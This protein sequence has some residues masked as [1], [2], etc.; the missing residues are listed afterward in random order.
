VLVLIFV[1][2]VPGKGGKQNPAPTET[3]SQI[4]TEVPT[5]SETPEETT[6]AETEAP[7]TYTTK[8]KLNVRSKPSTD[9]TRLGSLAAD[10]KVEFVKSY[11]DK[12]SVIM[13]E[14]KEAYIATEFLTKSEGASDST[15]KETTASSEPTKKAGQ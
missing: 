4:S 6:E 15:T 9:G 3:S 12:W 10:T 7:I 8:S 11:D 5:T 1:K 13:F 2:L 14:G